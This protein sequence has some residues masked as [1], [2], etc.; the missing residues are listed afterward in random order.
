MNEVPAWQR[1]WQ[2]RTQLSLIASLGYPLLAGLGSTYRYEVLGD[3]HRRAAEASGTPIFACWH[4]RI[5]G[6]TIHLRGRNIVVMTSQNFDGEW[7][8]RILHRF[9]FGTA[10]GSSSRGSR[11]ALRLLIRELRKRAVAFTVDGP[12]GPNRVAQPGAVW[13]AKATGHPVL[14]FHVEAQHHWTLRSWDGAQIPRPFTRVVVAYAEGFIVPRTTNDVGLEGHR[15]RLQE[16]LA[17]CEQTCFDALGRAA[18]Q[19]EP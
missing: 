12:R 3:E 15:V 6:G 14:P 1:S 17:Q 4:G 16:S 10:R 5:L 13:L 2:R 8:A 11:S 9:G 18:R 7:I 19:Q